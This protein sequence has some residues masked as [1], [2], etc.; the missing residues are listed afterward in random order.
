ME[1]GNPCIIGIQIPLSNILHWVI[2]RGYRR[3]K[4]EIIDPLG[5]M[6]AIHDYEMENLIKTSMGK[7]LLVIEKFPEEFLETLRN[8][9]VMAQV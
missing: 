8:E 5:Q 4:I 2:A 1:C 6:K 7:R 9:L 3:N